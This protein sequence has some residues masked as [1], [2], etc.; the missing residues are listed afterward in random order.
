MSRVA[1]G[2]QRIRHVGVGAE[3][4]RA[5]ERVARREEAQLRAA[6][7]VASSPVV[8]GPVMTFPGFWMP[9]VV[10]V[11]NPPGQPASPGQGPMPAAPP[12]NTYGRLQSRQPGSL[13]PPYGDPIVA[14][15]L[16]NR[17]VSGNSTTSATSS[18]S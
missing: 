11:V 16:Y 8:Y 1:Q 13:L 7:L 5:E 9:P 12:R 14:P 15:E 3:L 17:P 2:P 10:V 4:Q 6:E 18:G